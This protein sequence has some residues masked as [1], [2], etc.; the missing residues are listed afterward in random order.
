MSQTEYIT[1]ALTQFVKKISKYSYINANTAYLDHQK[2]QTDTNPKTEYNR[3]M[4]PIGS[5]FTG[6]YKNK[7]GEVFTCFI[8]NNGKYVVNDQQYNSLSEAA[9][10]VTGVRTEGLRFWKLYK[11][12]PSIL[13]K[14]RSSK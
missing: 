9:K 11:R 13:D 8:A 14:L 10:A 4:L 1:Q 5:V 2:I 12:G 6:I 3:D 7:P